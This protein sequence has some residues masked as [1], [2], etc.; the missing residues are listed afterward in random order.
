MNKPDQQSQFVEVTAFVVSAYVSKNRIPVTELTR[1]IA[2]T[3]ASIKRLGTKAE[4]LPSEPAKPAV[5]ISQ[6]VKP[7][8]I[9][10]LEDGKKFKSLK[11]HLAVSYGMTPDDYRAKWNLPANYPMVAPNYA[12]ERSAIAQRLG[13]GRK[14]QAVSAK[15]AVRANAKNA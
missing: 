8:F 15:R 6:S 3:Y 11:R 1:L 10:S 5:S 13:F 2:E 9:V 7:D 12:A 14:K 4:L